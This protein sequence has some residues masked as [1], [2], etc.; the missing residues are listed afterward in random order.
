MTLLR[1]A[2]SA[3]LILAGSAFCLLAALGLLRFPDTLTRLHAATKAQ[4]A[5]L[6][7]TLAGGALRT[8]AGASA[9]LLLIAVFLVLTAPVTAQIV[10]RVAYRTGAVRR[11]ALVCD[12][13]RDRLAREGDAPAP[14]A[15]GD[16]DEGK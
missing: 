14:Q 10:G 13:L 11:T 12:D 15:P 2:L 16:H 1:D 4:S 6:L 8:P 7:L 9:A 3:V 5:G